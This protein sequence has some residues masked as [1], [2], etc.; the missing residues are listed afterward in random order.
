IHTHRPLSWYS[1]NPVSW[2]TNQKARKESNNCILD[3]LANY[4]VI[5][6]IGPQGSGKSTTS[7]LIA[8]KYNARI[9]SQDVLKTKQQCYFAAHDYLTTHSNESPMAIIDSTNPQKSNRDFYSKLDKS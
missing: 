7:A 4:K 6:M 3:N 8:A 1:A 9:F 2:T 5:I